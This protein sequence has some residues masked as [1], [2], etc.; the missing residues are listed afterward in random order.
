[1][2]DDKLLKQIEGVRA[3]AAEKFGVNSTP[4][5]FINGKRL[6][7]ASLADFEKALE[8]ILQG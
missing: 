1:L 8:P 6:N 2:S 5:F 7:G 4:S 3:R